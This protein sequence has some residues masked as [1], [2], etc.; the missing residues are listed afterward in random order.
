[1]PKRTHNMWQVKQ[2]EPSQD[3]RTHRDAGTKTEQEERTHRIAQMVFQEIKKVELVAVNEIGETKRNA[4][5]FGHT[6]K[7]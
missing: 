5:G 3:V 7:Q 6:G 2:V 1:M 4:G